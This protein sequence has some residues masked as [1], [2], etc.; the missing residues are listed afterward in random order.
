LTA[1]RSGK[2]NV[3]YFSGRFDPQWNDLV[4][5]ESFPEAL[6]A[7]M[8]TEVFGPDSAG[9]STS[10]VR[11]VDARQLLPRQGSRK[12]AAPVK[13]NGVPLREPLLLAV[14]LLFGMERWLSHRQ[15]KQTAKKVTA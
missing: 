9:N 6:L 13:E 10:D 1:Q 3:Y 7:L 2:G 11:H 5:N 12:A 14:V 8:Q 15:H 4:W